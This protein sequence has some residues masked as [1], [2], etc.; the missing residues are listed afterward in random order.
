MNKIIGRSKR[1]KKYIV[2]VYHEVNEDHWSEVKYEG[3]DPKKAI[4][5]WVELERGEPT[6]VSINVRRKADAIELIDYAYENM[7][8]LMELCSQ[9]CFPYKADYIKK[10]IERQQA[11]ECPGFHE[12][13]TWDGEY[14]PDQVDPFALG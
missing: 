14:Y 6:M 2:D 11:T 9:E 5:I 13:Q 12:Y 1:M 4:E 7:D 8:W 3:N 10:A